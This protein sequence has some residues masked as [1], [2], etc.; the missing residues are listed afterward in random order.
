MSA[1]IGEVQW[2][3]SLSSGGGKG[4][5]AG[6]C[7]KPGFAAVGSREWREPREQAVV[8]VADRHRDPSGMSW[9][10]I[11]SA[12]SGPWAVQVSLLD[13]E[14]NGKSFSSVDGSD[15]VFRPVQQPAT[16]SRSLLQDF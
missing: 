3:P 10:G 9:V 5:E 7:F 12:G 13:V 11:F 4:W 2:Y 16:F 15:C 14:S 6:C 8:S 1:T